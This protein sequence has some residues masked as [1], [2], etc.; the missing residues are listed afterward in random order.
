M[1]GAIWVS[2]NI[3]STVNFL[4]AKYR[5]RISNKNLAS[6]LNEV[7]LRVKYISESNNLV[8]KKCTISH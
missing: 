2:P 5:S 8:Q 1:F 6:I 3:F 7:S 4:K